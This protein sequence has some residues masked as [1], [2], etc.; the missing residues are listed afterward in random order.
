MQKSS[1]FVL[2]LLSFMINSCS[3][4][5]QPELCDFSFE[6][7]N[8]EY[9]L[10]VPDSL[11]IGAPLL[12]VF[13]GYSSS[14][15]SIMEYSGLNKIANE[16]GFVV[17][18]PQGL[19]DSNGNRFWNVGYE[20]HNN[21][22]HDD[23]AF[24][25]ELAQYLQNEFLLSNYNTFS[26]GMSNGGDISYLLACQEPETFRAIAP[27][28]GCMMTWIYESCDPIQPIPVFEI[29]GT[30]DKVTWWD[31]ADDNNNDG[32]GPWESVD[33]TFNY[34]TELNEC[35][36]FLVDTLPNTNTSDGSYLIS[37]KNINVVNNNQVWLY[38]IINGAHDWPGAWGNMDINSSEE[39]WNFF[40][41]FMVEAQV[42]DMNFDQ[43]INIFDLLL[44]SESVIN[45]DP[46]IFLA[47]YDH[48]GS[49]NSNDINLVLVYILG[50]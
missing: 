41:Q 31:G 18:Y 12:F 20:F 5:G 36:I 25:K 8:R 2:I 21:E 43:T 37:H 24:A 26:T 13:H 11:E 38:E 29:H 16:N 22:T 50:L 49:I 39:I 28:A 7:E 42:G 33:T 4:K 27:V 35:T 6:G 40:D 23:V 48:N 9:Y 3:V 30:D 10:Y 17:C 32:W 15:N 45:S 44:I 19:S 34:F 1:S 46:Y 14:A 47:D